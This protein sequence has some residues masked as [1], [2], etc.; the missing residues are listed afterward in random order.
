M[1]ID[2]SYFVDGDLLIE[3]LSDGLSSPMA[4]ALTADVERYIDIHG[5]DYL[6][7]L[8]GDD[9]ARDF[10]SY[11][12]DSILTRPT[13]E[14]N[15]AYDALIGQLVSYHG[16]ERRSPMASYVYYWY[17]RDHQLRATGIGVTYANSDNRVVKSITLL[18]RVWNQMVDMNRS[19]VKD[20]LVA[21]GVE[22]VCQKELLEQINTL[23][24]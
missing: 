4:T 20:V 13:M 3:G 21:N 11:Y 18:T 8:L 17:V 10:I 15:E 12:E 23:G 1:L 2:T 7:K 22:F 24:I 19:I 9:V 14:A 16:T 5:R 6:Y